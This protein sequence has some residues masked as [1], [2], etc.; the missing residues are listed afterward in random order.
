[1]ET[2]DL[3]SLRTHFNRNRIL[4]CFNGPISRSLIEE[5]G[6]QEAALVAM[7]AGCVDRMRTLLNPEQFKEV[8]ALYKASLHKTHATQS[9]AR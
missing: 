5:I 2:I 8:V 7:R 4:L 9:A 1:M 3:F 6:K